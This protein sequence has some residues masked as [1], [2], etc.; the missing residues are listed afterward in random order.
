MI[1]ILNLVKKFKSVD[2]N[3]QPTF[4]IAVDNVTLKIRRNE[5]FGILGPN[6][7][8]KTTLI[9]MLTGQILPTAGKIFYDGKTFEEN[10]TAIKK[11]LGVVP[12]HINFDQDLN[13]GE[14]LELHARLYGMEKIDRRQRIDKLLSYMELADCKNYSVKKLS[15]GMK[16]RLLIAR[17]L[18]HRPQ[19][20]FLD[21]PTVALDPQVRRKIWALIEELAKGGVTIILTT[22]YIEEAEKLC[23]RTAIING[24]KLIAVDSP[25]NFCDR[26]GK[27][28][29]E[30]VFVELTGR[31]NSL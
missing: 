31:R 21:E 29:L 16:R 17:A 28:S 9:K 27:N 10:K 3:N 13:V 6:G 14:N 5:I 2:K 23:Q 26:L 12:Q 19:I 8:G 24:G 30:D 15:G 7:A 18:I 22:H 4:K 20:L 1:E 11:M 25:Q